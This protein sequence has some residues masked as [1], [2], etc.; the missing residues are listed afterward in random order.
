MQRKAGSAYQYNC[1]LVRG[2]L[3]LLEEMPSRYTAWVEAYFVGVPSTKMPPNASEELCSPSD[4]RG[5]NVVKYRTQVPSTP[6]GCCIGD[7][8]YIAEQVERLDDF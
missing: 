3:Q 5:S 4:R 8:A 6:R 1:P 2:F 7:S